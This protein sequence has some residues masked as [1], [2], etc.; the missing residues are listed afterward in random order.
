M[1]IH[2]EH[3]KIS[4]LVKGYVD[5]DENGVIGLDGKLN[6]RP[7]YQRE[8]VYDEKKAKAVIK[9]ITKG[10]PLNVMYWVKNGEKSYELLDGQQRTISICRFVKQLMYSDIYFNGTVVRGYH[11]LTETERKKID[12]Y[13]LM[14]YICEGTEEERL[15]WFRTINIAGLKLTDQELRN[16]Q[17]TGE[18]LTDA[19]RHFSK[20]NCPGYNLGKDYI[21][22][23]C[24]RQAY[25][26]IALKWIADYQNIKI[27]DYMSIHQHDINCNE[28]WM[29]YINVINWVKMIFPNVRKE[30]KG[31]DWGI[32]YNKYKDNNYDSKELEKQI[33]LLLKDDEVTSNKGIYEYLLS[34]NQKYLNLR[35]FSEN[36]KTIMFERQKGVCPLCKKTFK[37]DQM[38]GDHIIPWSEGGKTEIINGQM[39]CKNCNRTKSN[40]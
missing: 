10:F 27:E 39:L 8:F 13:E 4:D 21:N 12:D 37:Y 31:L 1:K 23:D 38:E 24:D 33:K 28:L 40:K 19:K 25:L 26:E 7:K 2:L 30:M 22:G 35:A 15:E 11:N 5:N 3:I 20:N 29:Y 6:I 14:I 18:W 34:G 16:A 17:Y 36:Q 32:F 9:T